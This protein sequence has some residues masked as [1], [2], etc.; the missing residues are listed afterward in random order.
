MSISYGSKVFLKIYDQYENVL[1]ENI[2]WVSQKHDD[3]DL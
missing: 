3:N 2:N 1:G